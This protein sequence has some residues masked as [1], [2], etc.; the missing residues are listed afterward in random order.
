LNE[1]LGTIRGHELKIA[2]DPDTALFLER[3]LPSLGD[4]RRR[5]IGDAFGN[6]WEL[7]LKH[8][9]GSHIVQTWLTLGA[10]TLDREARGVF[11]PD[12]DENA[13]SGVGV[14]PKMTELVKS[15]IESIIPNLGFMLAN[16]F[17]SP[18]VRLLWL[19]V[20]PGRELPSLDGSD[21]AS[22]MVRSKKS[23]KYRKGQGVQ[24]RSIFGEESKSKGK[25]K[26]KEDGERKIEKSLAKMRK[27]MR[28]SLMEKLSG[29]EWR[30]LGVNAVGCP[31]VQ[32]SPLDLI[33]TRIRVELIEATT[34]IRDR[35]WG[36]RE[37]ELAS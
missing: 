32:V 25:G 9:F 10:D 29:A 27:V 11:P 6:Q 13:Q 14:I 23:N 4:R 37:R 8:R 7:L 34:R 35:R 20:S 28:R 26:G 30:M 1:I 16:P 2:T 19:I 12:E 24:G 31:T 15:L 22:G 36:C 17:A 21:E 5:I 33:F 18:P 3:L